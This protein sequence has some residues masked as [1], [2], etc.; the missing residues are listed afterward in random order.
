MLRLF[1]EMGK[2]LRAKVLTRMVQRTE[3]LT[4]R[5]AKTTRALEASAAG[6]DTG[7]SVQEV[8]ERMRGG[9]V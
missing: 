2:T 3:T 7:Q 1:A 6:I 8:V 4:A 5:V 9:G